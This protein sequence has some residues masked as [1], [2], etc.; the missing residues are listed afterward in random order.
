M[1]SAWY[2]ER[3]KGS[4][5][6]F[7]IVKHNGQRRA[8]R[9][10]GSGPV[11]LA[12]AE[13]AVSRARNLMSLGQYELPSRHATGARATTVGQ[14]YT[15][16]FLQSIDALA[17]KTRR[18]YV[19]AFETHILPEIGRKRLLDIDRGTVKTF[20]ANLQTKKR[21]K[22]GRI[23]PGESPVLGGPLSWNSVRI[24]IAA[25][26][27]LLTHAVDDELIPRNTALKVGKFYNSAPPPNE[28]N[29]LSRSE[30]ELF[31]KSVV[32]HAPWHYVFFL[33]SL[34]TGVRPNECCAF[35]VGDVDF[36]GSF[37]EVRRH[38]VSGE[39]VW[40]TKTG[41]RRRV[42]VNAKLK[43]VLQEHVKQIRADAFK[44]GRGNIEELYLFANKH[45]G[46]VGEKTMERVLH[47]CLSRAGLR[48]IT[49]HDLRH[50][51]A[52]QHLS[53]DEELGIAP[54]D[55]WWVSKQLGHSSVAVTA[56]VYGHLQHDS[57]RKRNSS[58]P[59][60]TE[61]FAAIPIKKRRYSPEMSLGEA[62]TKGYDRKR[63]KVVA[64]K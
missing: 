18:S 52:S 25:L 8:K 11:A 15:K 56:D 20:I 28:I 33:T 24:I 48:R 36:S 38:I 51:F 19:Y 7:F 43:T 60:A 3:P 54:T 32:T 16:T 22:S 59:D 44:D 40:R 64:S 45:G 58:L 61:D 6:Y 14:Y 13:L 9:I 26:S 46:P 21:L 39:S 17:E 29:P 23:E 12:A 35:Q 10:R 62:A 57:H 1:S 27:S 31:L 41:K 42:E 4:E 47:R 53:G 49:L 5:T 34:Q 37:M 50:T 55:L 63:K 2:E 30:T